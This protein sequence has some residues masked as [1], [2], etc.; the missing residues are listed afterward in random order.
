MIPTGKNRII[1]PLS[2]QV[3]KNVNETVFMNTAGVRVLDY[4]KP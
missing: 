2:K 4:A 1:N 3:T